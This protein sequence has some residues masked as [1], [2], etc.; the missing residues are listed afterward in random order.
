MRSSLLSLGVAGVLAG[1]ATASPP[2][3]VQTGPNA[4]VSVDGLHRVDNSIMAV[5]YLKPDADL[6]AYS[7]IM[8]DPV[9]VAYK[10]DPRGRRRGAAVGG[11]DTNFEL[12]SRQMESLRSWFQGAVKEVF[13]EG[14]YRVVATPGPNVL[15]VTADLMDLIVRIP[16]E[17]G[18]RDRTFVASYGEVTM[19][20]EARDSESGEILARGAVRMSPTN[21]ARDLVAVSPTFVRRDTERMFRHWAERMRDRLDDLRGVR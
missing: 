19:V 16:T 6:S 14:T 2:P 10:K 17:S 3:T 20:V 18:G 21:A 12:S 9:T 11:G 7:A 8:L 15:R 5:G 13:S 4:E 1:C